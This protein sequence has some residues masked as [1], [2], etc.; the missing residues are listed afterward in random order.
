MTEEDA[1]RQQQ[2]YLDSV[3]KMFPKPMTG[4][5]VYYFKTFL[6]EQQHDGWWTQPQVQAYCNTKVSADGGVGWGSKSGAKK[7]PDGTPSLFGDPGRC[8]EQ[9]RTEKYDDCWDNQTGKK[10]GPFRLNVEKYKQ[11]S[12]STKCHSF[13]DKDKKE[14]L[15]RA[16]GKCELCGY[17]GTLEVDHFMPREKGGESVLSNGNALCSRCNDRKCNKDPSSFML[18][19]FERMRKYFMERGLTPP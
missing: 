18:E 2:E 17:K 14:I 1:A 9:I 13:S 10:D 7:N 19:E 12:G 11:F 5:L 6:L 15:K 16:G 3:L 8:L 4:S